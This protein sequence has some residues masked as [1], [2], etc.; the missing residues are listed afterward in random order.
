MRFMILH[1]TNAGAMEWSLYVGYLIL[2]A[3]ALAGG[4]VFRVLFSK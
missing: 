4:S 3:V 2:S 1:K